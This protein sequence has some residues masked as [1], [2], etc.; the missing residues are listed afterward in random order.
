MHPSFAFLGM[1]FEK[2][3]IIPECDSSLLTF[4]ERE[5]GIEGRRGEEGSGNI[6]LLVITVVE[7][8]PLSR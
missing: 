7:F 4:H 8:L 5:E 3:N 6:K 1:T 2:I